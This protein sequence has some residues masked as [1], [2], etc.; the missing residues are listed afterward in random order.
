MID[1]QNRLKIINI[2]CGHDMAQRTNK[3]PRK[4]SKGK[5]QRSRSQKSTTITSKATSQRQ[6]L[7]TE[8]VSILQRN[9]MYDDLYQVLTA[10]RIGLCELQELRETDIDQCR[11]EWNMNTR[12]T[13][14]CQKLMRITHGN[15]FDCEWQMQMIVIGDK[16]VGKTS[17]IQQYVLGERM[18][19]QYNHRR[20][21][22][23]QKLSDDSLVNITILD[24]SAVTLRKE[25]YK[26]ADCIFICF[27][28]TSDQSFV[29]AKNK[30]S[31]KK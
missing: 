26:N 4:E 13:K 25:D 24:G 10:N 14:K 22:K 29:N 19:S 3:Y 11:K 31:Q 20:M 27:D 7:D 28:V 1:R 6:D 23:T 2:N 8:L 18:T 15:D 16:G 17:L 21:N 9:N 12:Q 5:P 30:W